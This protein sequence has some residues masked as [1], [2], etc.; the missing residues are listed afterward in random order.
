[1]RTIALE[2]HFVTPA[3]VD[4]PGKTFR[5]NFVKAR[6]AAG[7][8]IY[9]KALDIGEKRIAEMDAAGIDMQV[10]SIN[11]P[12]T[13]QCEGDEAVAVAQEIN[14]TLAAAVRKHPTRLAGFAALPTAVPDKAA[15][16]LERR[17]RQDGFK[18]ALINGHVRGRYL[19]DNFFWP[20]LECAEALGVP[21]YL[22]PAMPPKAVIEGSYGG[23]T[24]AETVMLAG[25]GWG[26]HIETAVHVLRMMV[27]GVFDQFPKLQIV[28]GHMGEAL[29]FMMP[30]IDAVGSRSPG[31]KFK[32]TPGEYLRENLH[33]TFGGFNFDS[34][35]ANLLAEVGAGRI[36]FSIDYPYGAM[37]E[38]RA[39]L[40]KIPV[41]AADRERIAH[42]NAEALFKL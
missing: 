27:R 16:E 1:M 31:M 22:H 8:Q 35:F 6:G 12:G 18:G 23:F 10:L 9:A 7:E 19:D 4:G 17:V 33:Y 3:F 40:D 14:D 13:E 15:A 32:R 5:D 41:S 24:P 11:Y 29:P 38:A 42:G 2:E 26:W 30:R 37:A 20:I 28:I 25:P 39:F 36:M 21:I 34:T